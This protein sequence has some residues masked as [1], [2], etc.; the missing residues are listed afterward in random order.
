MI[1]IIDTR[2]ETVFD[3]D[4]GRW[5]TYCRQHKQLVN[6]ETRALAR[7]WARAPEE[8]CE[9]CRT[10]EVITEALAGGATPEQAEKTAL[11]QSPLKSFV[12]YLPSI[13]DRVEHLRATGD[14]PARDEYD[15]PT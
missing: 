11:E 5:V 6:H 4:G 14:W 3:P 9:A 15:S 7:D 8:W 2:K 13:A 10:L 12:E 1:E